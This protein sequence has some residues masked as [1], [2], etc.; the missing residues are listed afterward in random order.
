MR[1]QELD[2]HHCSETTT[3]TTT[4][5]Y[6]RSSPFSASF[7]AAATAASSS[8]S[9]VP[10]TNK[11][12]D[13]GE[14]ARMRAALG[15]FLPQTAAETK[16]EN[17]ITT[18]PSIGTRRAG[19]T[20][21]YP[22]TPRRGVRVF[23]NLQVAH[24]APTTTTTSVVQPTSI[25]KP[26]STATPKQKLKQAVPQPTASQKKNKSAKKTTSSSSS[27]PVV[28][29]TAAVTKQPAAS[30]SSASS[31]NKKNKKRK[32]PSPP[33]PPAV[34]EDVDDTADVPSEK[35]QRRSVRSHDKAF[36]TDETKIALL[37][38]AGLSPEERRRKV[39]EAGCSFVDRN[40]GR[41]TS[42][43]GKPPLFRDAY[44]V[45]RK[46]TG[47]AIYHKRDL[48]N[49]PTARSCRLSSD[50]AVQAQ[51][52]PWVKTADDLP[53]TDEEKNLFAIMRRSAPY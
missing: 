36:V 21:V 49:W 27:T 53:L 20:T 29:A 11:A 46:A 41:T 8:L 16:S 4:S 22:K 18:T 13:V 45:S 25:L 23:G 28:A 50:P 39:W 7:S 1:R 34:E 10:S 37:Q 6:T 9:P 48:L 38:F 35:K 43:P 2:K 3:T 5:N 31:A 17:T 33:P 15:K 19:T 30:S 44:R 26:A 42:E 12:A 14:E 51:E 40:N 52:L 32:Q 24:I 47:S